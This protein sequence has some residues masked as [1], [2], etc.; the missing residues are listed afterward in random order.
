[1]QV[2]PTITQ[3]CH[4]VWQ[5]E[6]TIQLVQQGSEYLHVVTEVTPFHPVSHI[7]PD[8]PADKG[9]LNDNVVLDCQVGAVENASGEL[10]V[11]KAI[12]VKRDEEG[13][14]F[15]VVHCLNKQASSLT[16]GKLVTLNVDKAYQLSLSRGHSAGHLAYLALNKVLT[17]EGYWRKDADRKD[18]H[19]NYDFNSYAQVT[20]FVT[21][22]KCLDTYRLGKTL[23]KRGLNSGDML[24][25]LTVIEQLT[26]QQLV[27]WLSIDSPIEVE[28]HGEKLTDS[29]YWSCD[30]N[31]G[32]KVVLPCG[33]THA[34]SLSDYQSILVKLVQIDAN[35]IEMHTDVKAA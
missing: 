21:P 9:T 3:F 7:W 10:Y 15:V 29:R 4:N 19:G 6:S 11:G 32:Q 16:V 25:Q 34:T 27:E 1:M 22:D 2:T 30:L 33:G 12:P 8:H 23:R 24:E 35:N 26:N 17:K 5:L 28:C 18:P 20:S 14:S 13:W 31:E